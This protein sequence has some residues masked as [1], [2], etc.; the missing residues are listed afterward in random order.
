M[1]DSKIIELFFA[2][3]EDAVKQLSAKYGSVCMKTAY[4]IL[5]NQEDSEECVNDSYLAVWNTVP[6]KSPNPL[7]AFLLRIVRNISINRYEYNHAEK[8]IGN[9]QECLEE[10]AWC[11]SGK[12]TLEEQ[13]DA[14]LLASYIGEFLNTLNKTNRLIFVRR[15]WYMD[16]YSDIAKWT[17]LRENAVR[18]RLSRQRDALKTFLMKRGVIL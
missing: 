11:V 5:G 1:E 17:G 10:F 12:D 6:P 8:R 9:Y 15:Y 4:N 14:S 18:T 16:S 7:I 3:S 13:Y 2:R